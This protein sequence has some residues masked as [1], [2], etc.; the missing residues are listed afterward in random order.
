MS[1]WGKFDL[2]RIEWQGGSVR[3]SAGSSTQRGKSGCLAFVLTE[4]SLTLTFLLSAG[5][6]SS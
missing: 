1:C 5:P 6:W 3:S 2:S 4:V